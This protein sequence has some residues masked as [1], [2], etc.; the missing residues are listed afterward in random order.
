MSAP[1]QSLDTSKLNSSLCPPAAALLGD[2]DVD[3]ATA[4]MSGSSTA[5]PMIAAGPG[6][7]AAGA[8][9]ETSDD[10]ESYNDTAALREYF[11]HCRF[12]RVRSRFVVPVILVRSRNICRSSTLSHEAEVLEMEVTYSNH[13]N[14]RCF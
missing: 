4:P 3:V 11:E 8:T 1:D 5:E 6:S 9:S 7:V 14:Q 12:S 13:K 2:E 10:A